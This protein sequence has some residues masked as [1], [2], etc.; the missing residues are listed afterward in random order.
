[1]TFLYYGRLS[2]K[3][4]VNLLLDVW[5]KFNKDNAQ[6]IIM[7]DDNFSTENIEKSVK[8][9]TK[10]SEI[11]NVY[12]FKSML[13]EKVSEF[14]KISDIYINLSNKEGMSNSLLECMSSGLICIMKDNDTN[15]KIL[16]NKDFL[17]DSNNLNNILQKINYIYL[18]YDEL[19]RTI[20]YKNRKIILKSYKDNDILNK[21]LIKFNEIIGDKK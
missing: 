20:P 14:L 6:L 15:R 13:W 21:Y 7:G 4:N 18:N 12:Y 9:K 10:I 16:Q 17:V 2:K 8:I 5:K 3:K 19:K 11:K 1:M